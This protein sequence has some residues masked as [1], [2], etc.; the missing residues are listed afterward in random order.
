[1]FA[2]RHKWFESDVKKYLHRLCINDATV[3]AFIGQCRNHITLR[4]MIDTPEEYPAGEIA[5]T[6]ADA[7]ANP[8]TYAVP[9]PPAMWNIGEIEFKTEGI[10]HLSMGIQKAVFKFII[11][12][13]VLHRLGTTLQKRLECQLQAVQDL[14]V[15]YCPCR[16]Y[17]DDKFGGFI[18][19]TYRAMCMLSCFL[20][21]C[22]LEDDL[23]APPPRGEN[24]EP[25]HKWLKQDNITWMYLRD[26]E[27]SAAITAPEAK[28]QV[29]YSMELS[30]PFPIVNELPEPISTKEIRD[31]VFRMFNMF[32]AIFCTDIC[33][34]QA[35]NRATA[36]VM[37]FLSLMETLDL[38]LHPRRAKPIW[39]AKFNFMGLLRVCESF[40]PFNH[41]RNLYEGGVIGE[42]VV[43]DLRP[44]VAK[45]VHKK[46]STNLLLAHYRRRTLDM[47]IDAAEARDNQPD[48]CPLG[49][50][51]EVSKF[52]RYTT[53]AE[54]QY[55]IRKGRPLPILL[56]G[57]TTDW[58]VGAIIVA[59]KRWYFK[60]LV[61]A[62]DGEVVDDEYGL[63][64]HNLHLSNNEIFLG[65]VGDEFSKRLGE[66]NLSFW[67]YGI[68]L[69]DLITE[70]VPYKY[71]LLRSSWQYLD[72][73]CRWS[74]HD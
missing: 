66:L 69:P 51:V 11:R 18:A 60:E 41:V 34:V 44:L 15:A 54:V 59:Q 55:H 53:T 31:L 57:S 20:Y 8:E 46:W 52:K 35:K 16:F 10:M 12:W 1:M 29:A 2:I 9:R 22:L 23:I 73:H 68:V 45:G 30:E 74:E 33:G 65:K 49:E 72:R 40:V 26:I 24:P 13:A 4:S 61:F 36:S 28:A 47:L 43:K 7:I 39:V 14:K 19:E 50:E 32:R 67:D 58:R 63:A 6:T 17:K 25:Q 3:A 64:Y 38:K 21:R 37:R 70:V 42:G 27:Y 48:A 71:S 5:D 62:K 56:Y